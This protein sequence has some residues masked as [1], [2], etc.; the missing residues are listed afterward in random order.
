M[1]AVAVDCRRHTSLAV[2]VAA[3]ICSCLLVAR[4]SEHTAVVQPLHD[5]AAVAAVVAP[6]AADAV[7]VVAEP[8]AVDVVAVVA[9]VAV[10]AEVVVVAAAAARTPDDFA[11]RERLLCSGSNCSKMYFQTSD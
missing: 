5:A 9:A 1:P 4:P 6:A 10:A 8:V 7:V 2:V 11:T 3:D